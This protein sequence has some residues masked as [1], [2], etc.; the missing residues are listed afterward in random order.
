MVESEP[1]GDPR[2]HG[3]AEHIGPAQPEVV[4]E[5]ARVAAHLPRCVV[6]L[7]IELALSP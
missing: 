7:V 2:P 4:D 3:V 5:V 1:S 6:G